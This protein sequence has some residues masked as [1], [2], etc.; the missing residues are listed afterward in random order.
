MRVFI[1]KE[2]KTE[3]IKF[4]GS[5]KKL[6]LTL[7]INPEIVIVVR[8]NELV[9]EDDKLNDKDVIKILSVISGG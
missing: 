3:V 2:G 8:D 9:T 4:N 5:V 7:K 1:E 6:L